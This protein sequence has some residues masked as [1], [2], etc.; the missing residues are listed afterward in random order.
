MAKR[1][2]FPRQRDAL[3]RHRNLITYLLVVLGLLGALVGWGLLPDMVTIRPPTAAN[4]HYVPKGQGLLLN[5]CRPVLAL[6]KRVGL[7]GWLPHWAAVHLCPA[8]QQPGVRWLWN[9]MR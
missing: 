1:E 2:W 9:W 5:L 8:V 7:S 6:A 4:H 3:Q